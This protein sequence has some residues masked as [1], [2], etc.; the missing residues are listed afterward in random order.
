VVS[1]LLVAHQLRSWCSWISPES[2]EAAI[3]GI[4][5]SNMPTKRKPTSPVDSNEAAPKFMSLEEDDGLNDDVCEELKNT[6]RRKSRLE[7]PRYCEEWE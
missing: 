5:K 6:N 1:L 7:F 2:N 3:L 4:G